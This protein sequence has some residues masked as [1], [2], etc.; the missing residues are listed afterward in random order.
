MR[1]YRYDGID[2]I[3]IA[4][5]GFVSSQLRQPLIDAKAQHYVHA[6]VQIG[7]SRLWT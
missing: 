4:A 5:T 7:G 2:F 3:M 6:T 1:G